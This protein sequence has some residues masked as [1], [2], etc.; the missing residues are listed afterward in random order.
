MRANELYHLLG[1]RLFQLL[2]IFFPSDQK[3][4]KTTQIV[5]LQQCTNINY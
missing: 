1:H 5:N 3:N 4:K 2:L